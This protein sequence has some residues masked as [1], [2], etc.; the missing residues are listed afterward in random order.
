MDSPASRT[1]SP[2]W[3]VPIAGDPIRDGHVTITRDGR[4]AAVG[5]GRPPH[6]TL[7]PDHVLLPALV[8]AHTHIELSYL[9]G[10]V[11]PSTSFNEWVMALMA[12]RREFPDPADPTIVD[13]AKR[14]VTDAHATGTGLV[15]DVNN[16]LA[17][18]DALTDARMPAHV[19]HELIGFNPRD[20]AA[21]IARARAA[22]G[23]TRAAN[24][25]RISLAPHAPYS[26]SRALFAA[27]REYVD[28]D[29]YPMTS[30]HLG[31]SPAEVELLRT[32]TGPAR[33]MLERL[34]VWTD[35]W[36]PP[37]VSPVSYLADMGF[38]DSRTLIVHGVQFDSDDLA[39]LCGIGCTLVSCPRSNVH[40]GVG[41]PPLEAFYEC[42][43]QVAIGTDS[44]A[45]CPDLN[46]FA[47]L[48]TMRALAPDVP[49]ARLLESATLTG[50][51]ALGFE[52]ELGSIEPGKRAS[53]I[54]VEVPAG[55]SDVEE[56]LL[57][58]IEPDAITWV[59]C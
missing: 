49:A 6:A 2:T 22:V 30:V 21:R 20:A 48:A 39:R 28:Q 43:V 54:A 32:G 57:S 35:E 45:S 31:E 44:L 4:I 11:A 16:T 47:E 51:R 7:L 14:A 42:G 25:V 34:G 18:I 50:A 40:V 13:A 12:R 38:I 46:V 56:Y 59:T 55:V 3:I 58:G 5:E 36:K 17:T 8:N 26:V 23:A 41:S 29:P 33:T 52:Q 27:I 53:L 15:G 19:F 24:D 37:G 1:Y 9:H 10:Q